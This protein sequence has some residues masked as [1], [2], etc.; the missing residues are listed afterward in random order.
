MRISPEEVSAALAMLWSQFEVVKPDTADL[1][2]GQGDLDVSH[3]QY[4][5]GHRENVHVE[6]VSEICGAW[7][8]SSG[9]IR[10]E[11]MRK[12][13]DQMNVARLAGLCYPDAPLD[14]LIFIAKF[15]TWVFLEDDVYDNGEIVHDPRQVEETFSLYAEVLSGRVDGSEH[16]VMTTELGRLRAELAAVMPRPWMTRFCASMEDF[17]FRGVLC[18]S[19]LRQAGRVPLLDDYMKMR[20]YSIGV[21]PVMQLVEFASGFALPNNLVFERKLQELSW[22]TARII[23]YTNDIFSFEKERLVDDPHNYLYVLTHNKKVNLGQAMD[24]LIRDHEND[25]AALQAVIADL[26]AFGADVAAQVKQYIDGHCLWI[27][28]VFDWQRTSKRYEV[29][30]YV[31]T[32]ALGTR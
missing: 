12:R 25:L 19:E 22:L 29:S 30:H 10:C 31:V 20:V 17:W 13:Y 18:E 27:R 26:P 1:T 6:Q 8:S 7:V 15:F 11:Q 23:G 24:Q 3:I 2:A 5:W 4:P 16:G 9:I 28:G 14:R 21:V 32:P